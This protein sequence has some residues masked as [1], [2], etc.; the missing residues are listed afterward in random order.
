MV[1]VPHRVR[2]DVEVNRRWTAE[3]QALRSTSG[4]LGCV[5]SARAGD[6]G[7]KTAAKDYLAGPLDRLLVDVKRTRVCRTRYAVRQ[8]RVSYPAWRIGRGNSSK[9]FSSAPRLLVHA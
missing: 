3:M 8:R 4:F 6:E 2:S 7:R 5:E 1:C 9:A